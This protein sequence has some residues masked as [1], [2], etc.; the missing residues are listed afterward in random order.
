MSCLF[1]MFNYKLTKT[2][3]IQSLT[4][5]SWQNTL[6]TW[7]YAGKE[8]WNWLHVLFWKKIS[9]SIHV[10]FRN[11]ILFHDIPEKRIR[12]KGKEQKPYHFKQRLYS[13]LSSAAPIWWSCGTT[14]SSSE[15]CVFLCLCC[16]VTLWSVV[17]TA[18]QEPQ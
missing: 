14:S 11:C 6:Y 8:H 4:S 18:L 15:K 5:W 3:N 2:I 17:F 13:V 10:D 16:S 12:K 9:V 1:K 7:Y